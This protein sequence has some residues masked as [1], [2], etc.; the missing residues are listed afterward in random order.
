MSAFGKDFFLAIEKQCQQVK[1]TRDKNAR[2]NTTLKEQQERLDSALAELLEQREIIKAPVDNSRETDSQSNATNKVLL[3]KNKEEGPCVEFHL[4]TDNSLDQNSTISSQLDE[5]TLNSPPKGIS[6]RDSDSS[7]VSSH[8]NSKL[9]PPSASGP[10]SSAKSPVSYSKNR[11]LNLRRSGSL[12][13]ASQSNSP[14]PLHGLSQGNSQSTNC[15]PTDV[16]RPVTQ[17]S[18]VRAGKGSD[19]PELPKNKTAVPRRKIPTLKV[20]FR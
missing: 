10:K 15:I 9:R 5:M 1:K 14:T 12:S 17:S 3:Q 4:K 8:R 11:T 2:E 13:R 19:A 6:D 18:V 16:N 20:P 7:S